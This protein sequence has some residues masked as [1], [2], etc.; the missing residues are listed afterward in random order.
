MNKWLK[1]GTLATVAA[2]AALLSLGSVAAFAQGPTTG[3]PPAYGR[4]LGMGPGFGGRFGG[5]QNSLVAVAAKE[6]GMDQTALVAELNAGKTLAEVAKAKN[7]ATDKIVNAFVASRAQA[8]QAAVTAK[9]ITQAQAD[10]TLAAMKAH[11]QTQL[12]SKYTPQ[13]YGAGLGFVDAN[14]DGICDNY[15]T[16]GATSRPA[17]QLSGPRGRWAR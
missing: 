10:A 12:T 15:A 2:V 11:A 16:M 1:I 9:Q 6:L 13:G 4:G 17:G 5:P 7:V 3:T 8:L 14:K